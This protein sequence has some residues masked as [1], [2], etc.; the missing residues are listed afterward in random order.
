MEMKE[1]RL[2]SKTELFTMIDNLKAELLALRFQSATGQLEN[3][4]KI[5][6]IKKD[7]ARVYTALYEMKAKD[8]KTTTKTATTKP[9]V[10]KVATAKPAA[11]KTEA[12]KPAAT[13]TE[14]AKPAVAKVAT[15]PAAAKPAVKKVA[16]KTTKKPAVKKGA[17]K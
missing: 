1:A 10:T 16:A 8:I 12:A 5:S 15:K 3:P 2:K 4:H 6:E 9:V 7:I 17:T 14:A 13:K 11:T